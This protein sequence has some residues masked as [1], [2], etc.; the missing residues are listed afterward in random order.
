VIAPDG[1]SW[2]GSVSSTGGPEIEVKLE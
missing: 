2:Q 1:Q